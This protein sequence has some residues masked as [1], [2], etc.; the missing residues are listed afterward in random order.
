[1]KT[2]MKNVK[3]MFIIATAIISIAACKKENQKKNT[4]LKESNYQ[5]SSSIDSTLVKTGSKA[6][7]ELSGFYSPRGR[8]V[9]YMINYKNINPS[10]IQF[11]T[12]KNEV[13]AT[14]PKISEKYSP[15]MKGEILLSTDQANILLAQKLHIVM[16]SGKFPNGEIK[17]NVI[18]KKQ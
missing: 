7:G 17:G 1:M 12:E 16:L 5:I 18:S 2:Q 10:L 13:V 14:V 11:R 3:S 6:K 8:K 4:E 9:V 15:P